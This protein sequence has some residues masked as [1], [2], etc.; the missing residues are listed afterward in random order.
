VHYHGAGKGAMPNRTLLFQILRIPVVAVFYY[1]SAQLGILFLPPV[2]NLYALWLPAAVA[3]AAVLLRGGPAVAGVFVGALFFRLG[4]VSGPHALAIA[5]GVAFSRALAG[6]L[7]VYLI[8]TKAELWQRSPF[9]KGT[10]PW[11][12]SSSS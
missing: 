12:W 9:A 8:K 2:G 11:I 4:V 5:S 3:M 7:S 6:W 10:T 1:F